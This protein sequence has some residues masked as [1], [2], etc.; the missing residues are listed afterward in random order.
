M[1]ME[2]YSN[3]D[4]VTSTVSKPGAQSRRQTLAFEGEHGVEHPALQV[5]EVNV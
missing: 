2:L 5:A 3:G 4:V 1:V